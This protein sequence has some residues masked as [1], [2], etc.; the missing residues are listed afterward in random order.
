MTQKSMMWGLRVITHPQPEAKV[1]SPAG[2][3]VGPAGSSQRPKIKGH[4][5]SSVSYSLWSTSPN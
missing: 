2:E 1:I 4:R 3:I 5:I